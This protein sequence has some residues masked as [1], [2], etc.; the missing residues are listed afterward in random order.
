VWESVQ[1]VHGNFCEWSAA[2]RTC[3]H[4]FPALSANLAALHDA[5]APLGPCARKAHCTSLLAHACGEPGKNRRVPACAR[6]E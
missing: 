2:M 5:G 3:E 6:P 1:V 4:I